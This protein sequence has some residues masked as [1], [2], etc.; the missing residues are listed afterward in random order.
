MFYMLVA[1][2]AHG[3]YSAMPAHFSCRSAVQVS[4]ARDYWGCLLSP[5]YNSI[6]YKRRDDFITIP[7]LPRD[8]QGF[9]IAPHGTTFHASI[10]CF[11]WYDIAQYLAVWTKPHRSLA[12]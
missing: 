11:I 10:R 3:A 4:G 9:Y 12:Q 5:Q 6:H 1:L 8:F 7:L 2:N